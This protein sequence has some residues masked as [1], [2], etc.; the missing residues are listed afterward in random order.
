MAIYVAAKKISLPCP[1]YHQKSHFIQM[2]IY[3]NC[4]KRGGV[5]GLGICVNRS[6]SK[7]RKLLFNTDKYTV[8]TLH[9]E[10]V[11]ASFHWGIN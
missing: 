2:I 3:F 4:I 9:V 11:S 7:I 6:H 10:V 8:L 1:H 5:V